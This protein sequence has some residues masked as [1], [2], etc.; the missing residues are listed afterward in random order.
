MSAMA[1]TIAMINDGW[2]G[3][4]MAALTEKK[5]SKRAVS[6]QAGGGAGYLHS[7]LA[8]GKDPTIGKLMAVCEVLGASPTYILYGVDVRPEDAEVISAMRE[9]PLTRDAVLA[10]LKHNRPS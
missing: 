9:S 10:L 3:R 8:E 5:M 4:L 1:D 7:I 2:R 6:L